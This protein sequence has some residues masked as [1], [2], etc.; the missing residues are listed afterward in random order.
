M[1]VITYKFVDYDS[2]LKEWTCTTWKE[3][4]RAMRSLLVDGY[5][6]SGVEMR[7]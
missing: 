7:K 4:C 6:I 2:E 3:A 5:E 1:Y